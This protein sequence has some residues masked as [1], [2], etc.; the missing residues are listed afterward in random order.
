MKGASRSYKNGLAG[1]TGKG[2]AGY[3]G[4]GLAGHTRKGQ[5]VIERGTCTE[6]L[7]TEP[8]SHCEAGP[9]D[10]QTSTGRVFPLPQFSFTEKQIK[11]S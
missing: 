1:Y 2:L 8:H 10:S 7:E 11:T 5:Q 9:R 4:K 3:T 6:Q